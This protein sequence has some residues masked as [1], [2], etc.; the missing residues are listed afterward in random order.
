LGASTLSISVS[1][2]GSSVVREVWTNV[3]GTNVADIPT[4]T[5][6][7][8]TNV[9]GSLEGPTDYG[10]NYGERV[11][12]Y[13]T[14]P[15]S[16][17]YYFWIAGSASA[18]LWISD[19]SDPVNKVLRAW[20]APSANPSPP[21][22]YG[23]ASRQ[24]NLQKTQQSPWL[25]LVAG[26]QYY[27]EVLHKAGTGTADNWSVSWLQDPTGTNKTPTGVTPGYL[28]SRYYPP[29]PV[30]VPGTLY[31][32]NLLALPGVNS[33]GVGLASLRVDP[34]GS[35]ATLSFQFSNLKGAPTGESINSDPYLADPGELIFDISAAKPQANGSYLWNIQPTGPLGISDILEIISE[36]KASINIESSAFPSGEISGHFTAANGSQ[37]FT[38]PPPPPA[39]TDDS[40]NSNAAVRFL[41]QATFGASPSDVAAVQSLGYNNWI[42]N[43]FSLP[44]THQL[45]Y[46]LANPNSDP[47]DPYQSYLTFDSWWRAS[48]TAPD[49]LR[50][51]IAFALSEILVISENGVLVNHATAL[52]SYYDML[53]DNAF[54]NFRSL[55]ENVTLHPAMGL[56]L[57]MLG[58]NAGSEITGV[59]ADE[60]YAREIQQ[61]FSIG[62]NREWPDGTLILNAQGNLVPTYNQNVIMGFA[63]VFTGW[64][65]FQTNQGN[66][67]LPANWYP[68]VNYTNPMVLVPTHHEL[69]TKLL[70]DNVMLP[71]AQGNAGN[72]A[73]TNFD[74]YCSQDMEQALDCIFNNQNVAPLICRELIQRLVTS[75]PSR[76]YVYRVAEVFNDNGA[77]VRGDMRAVIRAILLDYE[78]RSS[79]LISQPDY[80]KQREALLRV[81][82]L[83]RAFPGPSPIAGVYSQTTNQFITVSTSS[84]HRLANGNTVLLTFTDTSGHAAP[85]TQG[86]GATV[87]N[88]TSFTVNSP[89]QLAGSY[90][91]TNGVLTAFISGNGLT[92]NDPS[93]LVFTTGGASD[94]LFHIATVIDAA[95]FTVTTTNMA[96]LAGSCLL[97]KLS[98]GGYTQTGT[99]ILISTT[100]P[101]GLSAG[102]SVYIHFTSGSAVD[103]TY[104][105]AS[106]SDPTHF[107]VTSETSVSQ[108]H[109]SLS[110]YSLDPPQLRRS[111]AVVVQE[112]T[113]NMGYTDSGGASSLMESPLRSPT[114]FNFYYPD[115][116]FPGA[117]ASAGLTT[118]EFQLTTDSGIASQM[119]FI[120]GSLLGN[121][122][123][124]N[125]LS[126]FAGGNGS[127]VLDLSPWMTVN[128]TANSGV[129]A[130]V[131]D[132]NSLLAAGALSAAAQ[133]AIV[134]YV[135]ST[136]F[137][138][139]S[140]PTQAQMRDRV[141]AV[142][143]L[144][145]SS[146]DYV[147]QK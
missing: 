69:G 18:Q 107:A 38:P 119:N 59:H 106:V 74:Y 146:P 97:P 131:N 61:L 114:V 32:A 92:T 89:Q 22:Q 143:H 66:G 36:G 109:N 75:S 41:A 62:L 113:W 110:V 71:A 4:G 84:P 121:Y 102:N 37:T 45:P 20:V 144:I 80:G 125:G 77:G 139:G 94:G 19:D 96:A 82:A 133:S 47:T 101:H 2:T 49:Q 30:N 103:G 141:R 51:R 39:W 138:Y 25:A 1:N 83:A 127:I 145:T 35:R 16:G 93:Y 9:L 112:G 70:L 14:A 135:A 111:G 68:G 76:D 132:L 43:Q 3:P 12:G 72:P 137:A 95:H 136:N 108:S 56:Y 147:I 116:E 10:S 63:S 120:E 15:V 29:L 23:T 98:A 40:A 55:L 104:T 33:E 53:L 60:N 79:D 5:P 73:L 11:R 67:R 26:R 54:G 100:G 21:P 115:F 78:A 52:S 57:D 129:P 117:L 81:T 34:T 42:S 122:G 126:S 85:T 27:V 130:L 142:V 44:A 13:I 88:A 118:P 134:S 65:Y 91:Q 105:I 140:P 50:Q 123:N 7:N 8:L 24:W 46:V 28:L 124:T 90:S 128:Y 31:S 99:S 48:V 58:N 17:N 87:L 6:A 86:Y 64:N